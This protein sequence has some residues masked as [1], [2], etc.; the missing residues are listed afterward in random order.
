[1]ISPTSHSLLA[2]DLPIDEPHR[3]AGSPPHILRGATP[4]PSQGSLSNY[5]FKGSS[6]SISVLD[7][8]TTTIFS[9]LVATASPSRTPLSDRSPRRHLHP[10]A[11]RG[12]SPPRR[13]HSAPHCARIDPPTPLLHPSAPLLQATIRAPARSRAA[14]LPTSPAR[15]QRPWVAIALRHR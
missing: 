15:C 4:V 1:M 5:L 11:G 13:W 10:P 14:T 12:V 2:V 8:S 3:T 9:P 7:S 6:F